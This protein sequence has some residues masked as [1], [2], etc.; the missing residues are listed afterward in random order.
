VSAGSTFGERFSFARDFQRFSGR[1]MS[2]GELARLLGF[3][4]QSEISTYKNRGAPP[5]AER[6]LIVA[7]QCG[8]DP[9]WLAF[10]NDSKAPAPIGWDVWL[11]RRQ[12]DDARAFSDGAEIPTLERESFDEEEPPTRA[13]GTSG[14]P[15]A[16][17]RR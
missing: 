16:K 11:Q 10:G 3:K 2:D 4:S 13:T 8:V 17:K 15:G 12:E 9:G 7:E 5:H 1:K 6:V 14:R